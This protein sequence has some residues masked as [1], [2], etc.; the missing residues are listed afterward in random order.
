M[1]GK[2]AERNCEYFESCFTRGNGCKY[3]PEDEKDKEKIKSCFE[4]VRRKKLAKEPCP[5]MADRG[6][7]EES[8]ACDKIT[9]RSLIPDKYQCHIGGKCIISY[10]SKEL[11]EIFLKD[12]NYQQQHYGKEKI[13][14]NDLLKFMDAIKKLFSA[15]KKAVA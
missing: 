11:R 14:S 7:T 10:L 6:Y 12:H 15:P 9:I 5:V 3:D 2:K 1:A 4:Y 13:D 8:C